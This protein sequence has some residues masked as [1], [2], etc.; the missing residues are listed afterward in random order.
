MPLGVT[1]RRQSRV[2]R[3]SGSRE[4][5]DQ[6]IGA[7]TLPFKP[8]KRAAL[9]PIGIVVTHPVHGE[10]DECRIRRALPG[11][12]AQQQESERDPKAPQRRGSG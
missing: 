7:Y 12:G 4:G 6:T 8:L 5:R 3:K 10:N 1:A 11:R 9:D 2:D